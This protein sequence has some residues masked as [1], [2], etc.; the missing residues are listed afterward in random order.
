M[1]HSAHQNQHHYRHNA[2]FFTTTL[3]GG[4][5]VTLNVNTPWWY[6]STEGLPQWMGGQK[7]L[8]SFVL[9]AL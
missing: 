6:M 3:M 5:T 8:F 4:G 9:S 2:N 7:L 1:A